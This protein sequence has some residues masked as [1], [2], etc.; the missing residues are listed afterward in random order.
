MWKNSLFIRSNAKQQ[1]CVVS[2]LVKET[3]LKDLCCVFAVI[4]IRNCA[5]RFLPSR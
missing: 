1:L 3:K 5:A 4:F 2:C